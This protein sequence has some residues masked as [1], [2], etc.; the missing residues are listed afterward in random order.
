MKSIYA[1]ATL[2][3][4][5]TEIKYVVDLIRRAG[6]PCLVI[7]SSCSG[8][9]SDQTHND[10]TRTILRA[11]ITREQVLASHSDQNSVAAAL[12][13]N[14]RGKIVTVMSNALKDFFREN[15]PSVAG[16]ISIGGSGGT[17]LSI[18]CMHELPLGIPKVMVSTMASGDVGPYVLGSDITMM[19]SVADVAGI[20]VISSEIL[21]NAAHAIA[22]MA[23]FRPNIR[24]QLQRKSTSDDNIAAAP[25]DERIN[26]GMSM[27]GVTTPCC[28]QIRASLEEQQRASSNNN[29]KKM[30]AICFHSTGSGGKAMNQLIEAQTLKG[31]LDI[32][33]TEL[34]D[35]LFGGVLSAGPERFDY[36]ETANQGEGIPAVM[37]LGA[38]DMI[39]FGAY[40]SLPDNYRSESG[41]TTYIHNEYV[42]LV[43]TTPEENKQMG[44]FLAHKIN[45]S[46]Q[47]FVLLIPEKGVSIIDTP[48]MP[49]HDEE[50]DTVLFETLEELVTQDDNRKIVRVPYAINDPE[51]A[52]LAT[53]MFTEV[54]GRA[55]VRIGTRIVSSSEQ[56]TTTLVP[57][58]GDLSS[59]DQNPAA[60]SS[61]VYG[62][63]DK[64]LPRLLDI[65]NDGVPIIGAGA[66][67][68][69]SAKFEAAGGADLIIVYNSGRFRM[70]GH[71]SLAGLLPFKDA[72]A[73]MLEMGTEIL[74]ITKKTNTPLLAGVCATDPFRDMDQLLKQCKD[75][76][77]AGV[78]NFPTVGLMDGNFRVNLEQTGM[79]YDKEVEMIRIAKEKYGLLTTP[80]CFNE[81][82]AKQMARAGADII[83]AHLGLTKGGSIGSSGSTTST[84]A[85]SAQIVQ[86]IADA[87]RSINP[88]VIVLCH[89]GPIAMPC[90]AEYVLRNTSGVHGFYGASSME[91]LPV[92]L[93]ITA[94]MK[95]F[96]NIVF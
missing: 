84:L 5:A 52:K 49:F 82:E 87:A 95:K 24:E 89:G 70:G 46:K 81:H 83:V 45:K 40:D 1:I 22:G 9:Q 21:G 28:D 62:P 47:P 20:N 29:N 37:S 72:N 17:A 44:V 10:N 35:E 78:Q 65:M 39:N 7:D 33:T 85:E 74:P 57:K 25:F 96:K 77:F 26:V 42:T 75:M 34:C 16:V 4:K 63:R 32:T 2:D 27:F 60:A 31:V 53:D 55:T 18:P 86:T 11:D 64:I 51:F 71:G 79:G 36:L 41:R 76:G 61:T 13:T 8:R 23:K 88:N 3:T 73:V 90:D 91:R 43:R 66:G 14:D 50:A 92:E 48:G 80:Y 68:G 59:L 94:Q 93:A 56:A 67:T 54:M 6:L 69:I 12:S 58:D 38:C 19:Y 15:S 30:D